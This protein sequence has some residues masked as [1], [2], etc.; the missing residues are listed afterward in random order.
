M[1]S[2]RPGGR[3][4]GLVEC[5]E[6]RGDPLGRGGIDSEFVVSAAK[7]LDEGVPGD[8]DLR[9]PIS[10]QSAHRSE[11]ALELTVVGFDRVVRVLLDVVPRRAQQ[12]I[13]YGWVDRSGVGNHLAGGSPSGPGAPE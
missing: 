9:G 2:A 1:H 4:D 10:L 5:G 11:P 8:H 13:E 3:S 12:L 6:R 7:V